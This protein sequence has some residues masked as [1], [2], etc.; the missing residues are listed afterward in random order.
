MRTEYEEYRETGMLGGYDPDR[1][2]LR[3]TENGETVYPTG[4]HKS[5]ETLRAVGFLL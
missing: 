2:M 3:E 5:M 1:A 4:L